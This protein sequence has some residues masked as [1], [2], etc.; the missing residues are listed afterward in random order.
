EVSL[1]E[2]RFEEVKAY[3]FE[4]TGL[5]S[6]EEKIEPEENKGT[7]P[8]QSSTTAA[9]AAAN[10]FPE[11]CLVLQSLLKKK[12]EQVTLACWSSAYVRVRGS[13]SMED[14]LSISLCL[15]GLGGG[16]HDRASENSPSPVILQQEEKAEKAGHAS[17]L[18]CEGGPPRVRVCMALVH[19]WQELNRLVAVVDT[20]RPC[21]GLR[22]HTC[23]S[24]YGGRSHVARGGHAGGV[25]RHWYMVNPYQSRPGA[26]I[27]LSDQDIK[28]CNGS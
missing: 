23:E 18:H 13:N 6:E 11:G 25:D 22:P 17:T 21:S 26:G 1:S 3:I 27:G 5:E 8:H 20:F 16:K 12:E 10:H 2:A 9:A 24:V 15:L 19:T 28:P 14:V 4:A 7:T